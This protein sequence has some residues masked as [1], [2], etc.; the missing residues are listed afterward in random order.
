MPI[1]PLYLPGCL[2]YLRQGAI[3]LFLALRAFFGLQALRKQTIQASEQ[4]GQPLLKGFFVSF[5]NLVN[6]PGM[7]AQ[8]TVLGALNIERQLP[9]DRE[10]NH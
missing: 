8:T 10:E 7:F 1:S 2:N 9:V 3:L 6:I 5:F 4:K